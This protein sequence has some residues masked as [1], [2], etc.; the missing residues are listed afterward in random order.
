M[1]KTYLRYVKDSCFGVIASGNANSVY[2]EEGTHII[3]PALEDAKVWNIRTGLETA[4][5]HDIDNKAE[6]TAILRSPNKDDY[7]VGYD[8]VYL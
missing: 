7:A 2:N 1:V 3:T 6:V 8:S 4:C 5:W